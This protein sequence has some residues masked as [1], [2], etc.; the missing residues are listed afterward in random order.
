M[1]VVRAALGQHNIRTHHQYRLMA[2][3]HAMNESFVTF[4]T[5]YAGG[6]HMQHRAGLAT[7]LP[8]GT[9]TVM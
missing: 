5:G 9:A 6:A 3:V 7:G 2:S 4:I 8:V 1:H